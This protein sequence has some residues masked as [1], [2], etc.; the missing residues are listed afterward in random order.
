MKRS[1]AGD[2]DAA[3]EVGPSGRASRRA[4]PTSFVACFGDG[5]LEA[6]LRADK[7]GQDELP[8]DA[9]PGAGGPLPEEPVAGRPTG[10]GMRRGAR[11]SKDDL[12]EQVCSGGNV[13]LLD[14]LQP[15]ALS[16]D[17]FPIPRSFSPGIQLRNCLA[18][19]E[20]LGFVPP[21]ALVDEEIP[22][23]PPGIERDPGLYCMVRNHIIAKWRKNVLEPLSEVR[24]RD[25]ERHGPVRLLCPNRLPGTHCFVFF[26]LGP[27]PPCRHPRVDHF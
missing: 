9:D 12:A 18:Q 22:F 27:R 24:G 6:A 4:R 1:P 25:G 11:M 5:G 7:A 26:F 21:D 15:T 13:Q 2:A 19:A 3:P 20:S 8:D 17:R 10:R 16:R 14:A 23:V